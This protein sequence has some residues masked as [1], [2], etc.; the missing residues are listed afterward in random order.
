MNFI[1]NRGVKIMQCREV[2]EQNIQF[3]GLDDEVASAA[4][5]MREAE[6]GFLPV[7]DPENN[8]IVGTLTDRDI[9]IRLAAEGKEPQIPVSDVM[10]TAPIFCHSNDDIDKARELMESHQVSRIIVLDDNDGLAGIISLRDITDNESSGQTLHEI[11][12][13]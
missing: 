3:V 2:M 11:K 9:A 1:H 8:K 7:C 5:T 13:P 12:R 4:K 10:T 6:I